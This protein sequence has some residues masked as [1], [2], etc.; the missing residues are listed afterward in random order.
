MHRRTIVL[1]CVLACAVAAGAAATIVSAEPAGITASSIVDA[2]E[3]V[4]LQAYCF[5][6]NRTELALKREECDLLAEDGGFQH[7][8]LRPRNANDEEVLV[9]CPFVGE[10]EK[11]AE[12]Y[13]CL[14]VGQP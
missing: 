6:P 12:K 7:G 10:G 14:G 9:K 13:M 1:S 11:P 5:V 4:F 2:D 8:V 3:P